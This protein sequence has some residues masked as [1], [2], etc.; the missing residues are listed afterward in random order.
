MDSIN[1][2][3]RNKNTYLND[4]TYVNI[5]N[6]LK[7]INDTTSGSNLDLLGKYCYRY[8]NTLLNLKI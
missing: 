2:R 7:I 3:Y 4:T 6:P 5:N 1:F 8:Y